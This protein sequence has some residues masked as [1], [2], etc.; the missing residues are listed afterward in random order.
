[1]QVRGQVAGQFDEPLADQAVELNKEASHAFDLGV[2][3]RLTG[4]KYVRVTVILAAALFLIAIGQR[5]RGIGEMFTI[6]KTWPDHPENAAWIQ[7]IEDILT[8]KDTGID[9]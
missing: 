4:E 6:V 8:G 9:G 3:T 7:K 2:S 5:N 1:M